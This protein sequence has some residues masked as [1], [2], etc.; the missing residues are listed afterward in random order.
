MEIISFIN[1]GC[2]QLT[3]TVSPSVNALGIHMVLGLATIMMVWFGVQEALAASHGGPGFHMGRFLNFVMLISFAYAF[4]NYYDSTIPGIGYS[5]QG[6]IIGG[7][8][9]LVDL[10]GTDATT[11]MLSTIRV[12]LSQSGP[13][14]AAFTEPY[15]MFAYFFVQVVLAILA[16]L[17]SVIIAYGAVAGTVV[18]IL[19]PVFIPFLVIEKLEWLFWGWFKAFLGFA[20][21]K[22]VAAAVLSILGQLYM[23][24]YASLVDFTHPLDMLKNVPL[25]IILVLVNAYILIKIPALT[26]SLFSGSTSGH[27]AGTS[28]ATALALRG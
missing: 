18:G 11:Q 17:V 20:F 21:Y 27:D 2:S 4:V 28:I 6:F 5:L 25:L 8:D 19:G 14:I 26:A 23:R 3:A 16:G 13:G 7:T 9:S 1:T 24:Y 22:V 12:S 10:I 15:L